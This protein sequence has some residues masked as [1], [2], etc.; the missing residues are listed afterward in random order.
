MEEETARRLFADYEP[1]PII[2]PEVEETWVRPAEEGDLPMVARLIA[3][4]E[5]KSIAEVLAHLRAK[6]GVGDSNAAVFV[7]GFAHA[8][9]EPRA[10]A[11]VARFDP[12]PESPARVAPAG[13]YLTG[14]IVEASARRRGL[15]R[16]LTTARL[17]WIDLRGAEAYYFCNARN[18]ASIDL[19]AGFGF[20]ELTRDFWFPEVAFVGG[21]GVLFRRPHA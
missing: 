5:A 13:E 2:R 3:E 6:R 16:G 4:R 20:V 10:F 17:A 1:N 9:R 19:H 7:A 11:R 18:R 12:P 21:E 8:G 14:V 15:A